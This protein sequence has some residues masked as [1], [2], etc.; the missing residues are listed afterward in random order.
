MPI[1]IRYK[2]VSCEISQTIQDH[3]DFI[4]W[5]FRDLY[6]FKPIRYI[7]IYIWISLIYNTWYMFYIF[8]IKSDW[9]YNPYLVGW[10]HWPQANSLKVKLPRLANLAKR[11]ARTHAKA[12][13]K[14]TKFLL[15]WRGVDKQKDGMHVWPGWDAL[16]IDFFLF[17]NKNLGTT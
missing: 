2:S 13:A 16:W 9:F 14:E 8:A 11:A 3:M 5:G 6:I 1:K 15:S 10:R 4:A 17:F 12:S 7:Y